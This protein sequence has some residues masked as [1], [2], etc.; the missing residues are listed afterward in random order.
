M[1]LA[2][3][4]DLVSRGYTP[5]IRHG[6]R[7]YCRE[8]SV[9]GTHFTQKKC[10]TADQIK[11]AAESTKDYLNA[12]RPGRELQCDEMQLRWHF[13]PVIFSHRIRHCP[14]TWLV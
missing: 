2:I 3:D 11:E 12:P 7:V 10:M 5:A 14:L 4:Q 9:T 1:A 13:R 6:Q 8:Q